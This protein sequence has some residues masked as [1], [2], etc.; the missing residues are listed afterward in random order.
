MFSGIVVRG[1]GIGRTMGYP[2][3]NLDTPQRKV[4]LDPGVYAVWVT[5]RRKKYKGALAIQDKP[6]KVEVHL[7][8]YN[9]GDFY[10][11]YLEVEP[12]QKVSEMCV[13][14][15]KYELKEKIDRDL[16]MVRG[17]FE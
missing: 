12:M 8:G 4:D 2:T 15:S 14:N 7:I 3:A 6:W 9:A 5:L 1:D 13:F 10:G 16:E 17:V 11:T